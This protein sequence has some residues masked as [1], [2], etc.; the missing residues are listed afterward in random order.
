M[1]RQLVWSMQI[2]SDTDGT[3]MFFLNWLQNHIYYTR[4]LCPPLSANQALVH[5]SKHARWCVNIFTY[6]HCSNCNFFFFFNSS[7]QVFFFFLWGKQKSQHLISSVTECDTSDSGRKAT[8]G[9]VKKEEKRP[10]WSR[11]PKPHC[12]LV[13]GRRQLVREGLVFARASKR[14]THSESAMKA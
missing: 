2:V 3:E 8:V 12:N 11:N 10:L 5:T 1:V 9:E 14:L 4:P 13:I 7:L 6:I